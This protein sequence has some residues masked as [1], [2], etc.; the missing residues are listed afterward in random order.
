MRKELELEKGKNLNLNNL[1][2]SNKDIITELNSKIKSL[3]LQLKE[4]NTEL[5]NLKKKSNIPKAANDNPLKNVIAVAFSSADKKIICP[6]PCLITDKFVRL[7]EKFYE[8]YPEYG[9]RNTSFT[10]GGKE[11]LRFKTLQNNGINCSDI[12]L[13]K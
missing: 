1:I 12:I 11:I 8:K 7:E 5:D 6:L 13:I 9:E 10:I 4:K 2:N 3:E